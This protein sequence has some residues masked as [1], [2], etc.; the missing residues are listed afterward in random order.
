MM[1]KNNTQIMINYIQILLVCL[2][3]FAQHISKEL[4]E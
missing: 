4:N 1:M 3:M 2:L